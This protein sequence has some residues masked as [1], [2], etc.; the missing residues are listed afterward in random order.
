M[1]TSLVNEPRIE[2]IPSE[3]FSNV[4]SAL[5][6]RDIAIAKE[7]SGKDAKAV[8]AA[9]VYVCDAVIR[10]FANNLRYFQ[11]ATVETDL[12]GDRQ[13]NPNASREAIAIVIWVFGLAP[14]ILSFDVACQYGTQQVTENGVE[15]CLAFEPEHVRHAI[16]RGN[17]DIVKATLALIRATQGDVTYQNALQ[18]VGFYGVSYE[19]H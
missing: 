12:F 4:M 8:N 14:T 6:S 17:P 9:F 18:T 5:G 1:K 19:N 7:V 16:A 11:K 3:L 15:Q 10:D 2:A 13:V